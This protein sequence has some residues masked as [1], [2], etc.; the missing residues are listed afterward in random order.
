V[1]RRGSFVFKVIQSPPGLD[2]IRMPQTLV[3]VPGSGI[4]CAGACT[5]TGSFQRLILT[6]L[7]AG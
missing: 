5:R 2:K 6:L 7:V 1:V 4:A 3:Q